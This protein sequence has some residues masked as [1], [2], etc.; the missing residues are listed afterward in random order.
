MRD[1]SHDLCL[2][3]QPVVR[4]SD[5]GRTVRFGRNKAIGLLA[6]L[7]T[8]PKRPILRQEI[9]GF[10]WS[11][12]SEPA[13]RTS[14]RQVVH[15]IRAELGPEAL[16]SV[17]EN[18]LA[19]DPDLLRADVSAFTEYA[20]SAGIADLELAAA[21]YRGPF[22]DGFDLNDDAFDT[23]L[24][25]ERRH[26]EA[27][28]LSVLGR[29]TDHYRRASR[30]EDALN[31]ADLALR[32]D[33]LQEDIHRQIIELHVASGALCEAR[34]HAEHCRDLIRSELGVDPEPDTFR[35]LDD[36]SLVHPPAPRSARSVHQTIRH[37]T[38][39]D[40][41]SIACG[42]IGHGP[43][44]LKTPNWMTHLAFEEHSPVWRHFL[45]FF[46]EAHRFVRYDQRG[47]GLSDWD[48]PDISFDS[49]RIDLDAVVDAIVDEPAVVLGI[50]QGAPIAVD[51]AVRRPE[52]VRGLILLGGFVTGMA[53]RG[54]DAREASEAVDR[55]I[56]FGW[57]RDN[58]S[59]RMLYTSSLIPGGS[60][61]QMD[62]YNEM[63]RI[64]T[65]PENA[66]RIRHALSHID[67]SDL[68]A[69]VRVPTLV[70][71]AIG[72]R[73]SPLAEG[74]RLAR[75]IPNARLVPLDSDNHI[76]LENERAWTTFSM[77]ARHFLGSGLHPSTHGRRN[78]KA[79]S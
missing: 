64:G 78:V 73:I 38:A 13:A 70:C 4:A 33:P 50:S 24:I 66:V 41:T 53:R 44:L 68:L 51:L 74:E 17:D 28:A 5:T 49:F 36:P 72:D 32:I 60:K 15:T 45:E 14:L 57:G 11:E 9:A 48:C 71:H 2:L 77:E 43:T 46:S 79:S 7:A 37:V 62:W 54:D 3:G 27:Q 75:E 39:G 25:A 18:T 35:A 12:S 40:G 16:V 20:A 8:R 56:R 47:N 42:I 30:I 52:R 69:Q 76:P 21:L 10:L 19:I 59:L 1:R 63:M 23:W 22:L 31:S 34:K 65:S 6:L 61:R 67:I 58:P 26:L 55:L 29:L